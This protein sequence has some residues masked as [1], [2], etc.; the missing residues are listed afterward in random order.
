MFHRRRCA[1]RLGWIA[2]GLLIQG[3]VLT[4]AGTQDERAR[5][6][7]VGTAYDPALSERAPAPELPEQP[8]WRDLLQRA[9]L[10]NGDLEARY[11]EWKAAL[12][13]IDVAA[14]Y[15]NTNVALTF[16]YLF[17]GENV[18]GWDRA[19]LQ[20]GFDS[21]QNL[22]FPTK[23]AA[24]GRVALE[25]ARVA[26]ARFEATKFEIQE[27]LLT[28]YYDY[29]LAAERARLQRETLALLRLAAEAAAA[30]VRSGGAQQD[31]LAATIAVRLAES[32]LQTQESTLPQ[33]QTALNA[34]VGRRPDARLDPPDTLPPPRELPADDARLLAVGTERHPELAALAR[35]VAG[36]E[37]ALDLARQAFI[38]D[39]NPFAAINGNIAQIVGAAIVLP[40][41]IPA[42]RAAIRDAESQ[43]RGSEA[44][45]RQ[46]RLDREARFVATLVA[47]RNNEQ[48]VRILSESVLP[49]AT[50]QTASVR[51][52][53]A[54]GLGPMAPVIESEQTL[55]DARVALAEARMQ[56]EKRLAELE[57]LAGVDVETLMASPAGSAG[58]GAVLDET[59]DRRDAGPEPARPDG[60]ARS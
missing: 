56:R 17:S 6:A 10:T 1:V 35:T 53:Y 57:T 7:E 45:L 26:A 32:E 28:T 33:L 52:N 58:T 2:S 27:Q 14:A 34:L 29:A 3:C 23:V 38:P 31:L 13:R 16:N 41:T 21:M 22:S 12:A 18:K 9:F 44:T 54:A 15:P 19:T 59:R 20:A 25:D 47:L 43:L 50:T 51:Q 11:F 8:G 40:T 39:I 48:Q 46:A 24:K 37:N 30:G 4:P 55:V 5:L 60:E 49:A 42:I 36:R